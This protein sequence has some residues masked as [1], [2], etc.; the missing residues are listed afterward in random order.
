MRQD[1]IRTLAY[2]GR[3]QATLGLAAIGVGRPLMHSE[4]GNYSL[5]IN[6]S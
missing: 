1:F 6:N 2:C 4:G 5:M 3:V